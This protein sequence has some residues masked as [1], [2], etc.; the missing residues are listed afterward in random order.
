MSEDEE[1]R[2]LFVRHL[3]SELNDE[4]KEDLLKHFGAKSVRCMGNIGRY[5]NT[6][7][8]TFKNATHAGTALN[9]LHQLKVLTSKLVVE[10]SKASEKKFFSP[11]LDKICLKSDLK[12][13]KNSEPD[14]EHE[15]EAL[16]GT[17]NHIHEHL[18]YISA[19]WNIGYKYNPELMYSY[20]PPTASVLTNIANALAA[21]PKFYTQV[22]HLMNKM[23]LPAPFGPVTPT[24]PLPEE[25]PPIP[26]EPH[27][28]EDIPSTEES[29]LESDE[30]DKDKELENKPLK[31]Q[32][33]TPNIPR[34]KHKLQMIVPPQP[35]LA[36]EATRSVMVFD[37]TQQPSALKKFEFKVKLASSNTAADQ[38]TDQINQNDP[39]KLD[40]FL[41]PAPEPMNT[42]IPK[43]AN[44]GFGKI[45]PLRKQTEEQSESE[46]EES[47][48]MKFISS[49]K[50]QHGRISPSEMKDLSVY[51]KYDPGEPTPR[52][53][54][55]NIAKQTTDK[56]L[57]Y[58]YGR[59]VD[60]DNETETNMFDIRLMK[61]GRM[62]GQAFVTLPN[63]NIAQRALKD[64][65]GYELNGKPLVVQFARSAKPKEGQGELRNKK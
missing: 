63:Q 34:K 20:P 2:V 15:E 12:K 37:Q 42:T 54:V 56:E 4:D 33:K 23:N 58:I 5:K 62:K 35:K 49:S 38:Q 11:G 55:K 25:L 40:S 27:P 30:D 7:F 45:E 50:L 44:D 60:W 19:T 28:E 53:Y 9:R 1:N 18:D 29:E 59:Y 43:S 64:T 61:E 36:A 52:L 16:E 31:R 41:K 48:D 13:V 39:Y 47:K 6:A 22:L 26:N 32:K 10:F 57:H 14:K 24:P 3:P 8:A 17:S 21:V 65:N 51:K 46:N